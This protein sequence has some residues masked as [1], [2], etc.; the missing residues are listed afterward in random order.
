MRLPI[1]PI[2]FCS[3]AGSTQAHL[4]VCERAERKEEKM[5]KTLSISV[6]CTFFDVI[7][8]PSAHAAVRHHDVDVR[9]LTLP[10]LIDS[11][12]YI[13]GS[14]EGVSRGRGKPWSVLYTRDGK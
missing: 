4:C 9:L 8:D 11:H 5:A 2:T 7:P 1:L 3:G 14:P 12:G 6:M 10:V 13:F